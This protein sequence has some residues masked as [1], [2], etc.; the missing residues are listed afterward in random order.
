[1]NQKSIFAIIGLMTTALIGIVVVQSYWVRSAVQLN[2]EQFDNNVKQ[3]MNDVVAD[4]E[5]QED[6]KSVV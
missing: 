4:I 1:M 6:R 5:M 2:E 3:A